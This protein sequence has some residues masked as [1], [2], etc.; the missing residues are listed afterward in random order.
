MR[1]IEMESPKAAII[2]PVGR[3]LSSISLTATMLVALVLAGCTGA[4]AGSEAS[5]GSSSSGGPST[6]NGASTFWIAYSATSTG[7]GGQ[8]GLFV[9]PS[10][11][12][13]AAPTFLTS[14]ELR[15]L[16]AADTVT[17]G[18]NAVTARSPAVT[19][20]ASAG[21]DGNVHLYGVNLSDISATPMPTQIG[22]LSVSALTNICE[23]AQAQTD[24]TDPTTLFVLLHIAGPSGCN[25]SGDL[26][27][28][29]HYQD[30][31][32]TPP[33]AVGVTGF[34]P[35]YQSSGALSGLLSLDVSR[36]NLN[37]YT[38]DSFTNPA[39]LL[40]GV[41]AYNNLY[42]V[43]Q[44]N[45]PV[46]GEDFVFLN[47][48]IGTTNSLYRVTGSGTA[49]K[50]YTAAGSLGY[51]VAQDDTNL[52][53]TD[54]VSGTP[55]TVVF[56]QEPLTGVGTPMTLY[57]ATYTDGSTYR[58]IGSNG[59]VVLFDS[60]S[61]DPTTAASTSS[62]MTVPVG[63]SSTNA[64]II[65]SPFAGD[66]S[67][68]MAAPTP[69]DPPA[70]MLF[71]TVNNTSTK[72]GAITYSYSSEVLTPD[73]TVKQ[74]LLPNSAFLA[75]TSE[76]SSGIFQIK[77][78]TDT[79]GGFGGGSVYSVDM[80]TLAVTAF[81]TTGSGT[82]T[83]PAGYFATYFGVSSGIGVGD[84][85]SA[86]SA[87]AAVQDTAY[88]LTQQLML[89]VSLANT[90]VTPASPAPQPTGTPLFVH[91]A[92]DASHA[93]QQALTA[94]AGGTLT[95]TGADGTSYVLNIPP[96]ALP[97]DT[98]VS[99]TPLA[100]VSGLPLGGGLNNG[101][102][103][104][105]EGLILNTPAMLTIHPV[106]P[107]PLAQ[108][109]G[110][111][112]RALG[113]QFHLE[114]TSGDDTS[115]VMAVR[116][117]SGEGTTTGS[118]AQA[119]QFAQQYPAS[120][121]GDSISQQVM[122]LIMEFRAGQID[123]ATFDTS[124]GQLVGGYY[125]TV[126]NPQLTAGLNSDAA[127]STGAQDAII[128]LRQMQ[129]GGYAPDQMAIIA[130]EIEGLIKQGF[131]NEIDRASALC[132]N[133]QDYSQIERIIS[134]YRQGQILDYLPE[135][136]IDF[137]KFTGCM[138]F[139][140][141]PYPASAAVNVGGTQPFWL[142][143][144]NQQGLSLKNADRAIFSWTSGNASIASVT[145]DG[146]Q[147][148]IATGLQEGSTSIVPL[149]AS[150]YDA[151]T[152]GIGTTQ[153]G[154]ATLTVVK[155]A[156]CAAYLSVKNWSVNLVTSFSQKATG[157]PIGSNNETI[158]ATINHNLN[159]TFN[160]SGGNTAVWQGPATAGQAS[161]AD[162]SVTTILGPPPTSDTTTAT[163]SVIGG[164]TALSVFTLTIDP[165]A[166]TYGFSAGLF[167]EV[168]FTHDP[169][170]P[171]FTTSFFGDGVRR[172]GDTLSAVATGAVPTITGS[173]QLPAYNISS[174][175]LGSNPNLNAYVPQLGDAP[176][177]SEILGD[178]LG[179]T[180]TVSWTLTA[181][182]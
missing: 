139:A 78:I 132:T 175:M 22:N 52:Y 79:G 68:V 97:A 176:I 116:H 86:G 9:I 140:V 179:S 93:T 83:V 115:I 166:C 99:L 11:S 40:A 84:L 50:L 126:I 17:M 148:G 102:Q 104:A 172:A 58:V 75:R 85:S 160:I 89:S 65:G 142:N 67:V 30:S 69:D 47:V 41:S 174:P 163:G 144:F 145:A 106:T 155:K 92:T 38:N 59:S 110:F 27:E 134:A 71:V 152:A 113:D 107:V 43:N 149:A 111:G 180:A 66:I 60:A 73:G 181:T 48:M 82:Y 178:P 141:V 101:V 36:N 34:I 170:Q 19:I 94:A 21:A 81:A 171:P 114:P 95:A 105:P 177:L 182:P 109:I 122:V 167:G 165:V 2:H 24:L 70:D 158:T 42:D 137:T 161:V 31:P 125:E 46:L 64:T 12:L 15:I 14:N 133:N 80:G 112:Y 118:A 143:L 129:M 20:Y 1:T 57:S 63:L 164:G 135:E 131:F 153:Y 3:P 136:S 72:G 62:L 53:F 56:Y 168:T 138:I 147:Q 6:S 16:G 76:F 154:T 10:N 33:L 49:N 162:T 150:A 130:P 45:Q 121:Q 61:I 124:V 4:P 44:T 5:S 25:S 117:F 77:S 159:Y 127:F 55:S 128:F 90:N 98:T 156:D 54:T 51:T 26:Y 8:N 120:S 108:L 146:N 87:S 29:A 91:V 37:F 103:F 157:S 123:K 169:P 18:D 23:F 35:I 39:I 28:I 151:T 100:A 119:A 74:P 7:T 32:S 173:A 88:D 13:A 96:G